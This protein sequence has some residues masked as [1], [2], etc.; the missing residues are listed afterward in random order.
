[1]CA[2]RPHFARLATDRFCSA[3][4]I[5]R[6]C[7][8]VCTETHV[9][10]TTSAAS[11]S[12]LPP[13]P[14]PS[15]LSPL[16][17]PT[18]TDLPTSRPPDLPT[19]RPPTHTLSL[20]PSSSPF[21]GC[22]CDGAHALHR[23]ADWRRSRSAGRGQHGAP[24]QHLPPARRGRCVKV[25]AAADLAILHHVRFHMV[26]RER[27]RGVGGRGREVGKSSP[28]LPGGFQTGAP[29]YGALVVVFSLQRLP[30]AG[31]KKRMKWVS[32]CEHPCSPCG[33]LDRRF[34]LSSLKSKIFLLLLLLLPLV[35]LLLLPPLLLLLS[36]SF[37][38]F[39]SFFS[40]FS[41]SFSFFS[42]LPSPFS[43][44]L[45]LSLSLSVS[46]SHALSFSL[47]HS[48]LFAPC[49]LLLAL[50]PLPFT[51]YPL[52]F[53]LYPLPFTRWVSLFLGHLHTSPGDTNS[54]IHGKAPSPRIQA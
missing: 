19:S 31:D 52:R 51:H 28:R 37:L 32:V 47:S 7:A 33:E 41:F 11:S 44:S 13:S 16:P 49:S 10:H 22:R 2:V 3:F 12:L 8:R 20:P 40:F 4:L 50:Y 27:E 21:S 9:L 29:S 1:M 46:L 5:S 26:H 36:F 25:A 42:L 43:L 38:S 35:L 23:G 24:W 15:P 45:P 34:G 39:F 53:T 17:L 54:L 48:L 6:T 14:L 18:P 30:L